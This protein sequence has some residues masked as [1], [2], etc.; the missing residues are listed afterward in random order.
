MAKKLNLNLVA[1]DLAYFLS[2]IIKLEYAAFIK[3]Y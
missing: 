1:K 2:K 3:L